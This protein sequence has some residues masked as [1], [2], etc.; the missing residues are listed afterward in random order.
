M[1]DVTDQM[2]LPLRRRGSAL[3]ALTLGRHSGTFTDRQ[4]DL[5]AHGSA[6]VAAAVRRTDRDDG[7][8]LQLSPRLEWVPLEVAPGLGSS[9]AR[10]GGRP[11]PPA[12][13]P[14]EAQILRLVAEGLT[15]AQVA[16]RLGIR[17]ATVSRHLHR[18]YTRHDLGN[19][20]A[21]VRLLGKMA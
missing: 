13:S 2:A 5:L 15:D 12:L 9:A 21:A 6:H 8:G 11:D 7:I 3:H 10:P 18:V 16:R 1:P 4:R 20:V 14:R 19:R 17:P